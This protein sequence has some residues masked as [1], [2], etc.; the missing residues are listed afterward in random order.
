[1]Q[2]MHGIPAVFVTCAEQICVYEIYGWDSV[3]Q[4]GF[5]LSF[6]NS[7]ICKW[8]GIGVGK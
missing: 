5:V 1:M 6:L 2:M 7:Y 8:F 3:L 4:T